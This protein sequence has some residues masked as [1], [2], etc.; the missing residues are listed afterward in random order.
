MDSQNITLEGKVNKFVNRVRFGKGFGIPE[1]LH[2]ALYQMHNIPAAACNKL[3]NWSSYTTA[4]VNS[5]LGYGALV[6]YAASASD[7]MFSKGPENLDSPENIITGIGA[8][9]VLGL[10]GRLFYK[11]MQRADVA[12]AREQALNLRNLDEAFEHEQ[13]V[14]RKKLV[15]NAP[16]YAASLPMWYGFMKICSL[17]GSLSMDDPAVKGIIV[18]GTLATYFV[19]APQYLLTTNYKKNDNAKSKREK[20]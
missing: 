14:E 19:N 8:A 20:N 1:T 17:T 5:I 9:L 13:I 16:W 7:L 18:S 6:A 12:Q 10:Y 3:F 11:N 2:K 4:K 15:Q